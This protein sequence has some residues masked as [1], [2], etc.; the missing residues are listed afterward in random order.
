MTVD[1]MENSKKISEEA[2]ELVNEIKEKQKNLDDLQSTCKHPDYSLKNVGPETGSLFDLNRICN[3][4]HKKIG[5]A[6]Q[7]ELKNWLKD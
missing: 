7:E 1:I 6:D 3:L 4:C 5:K 2:S